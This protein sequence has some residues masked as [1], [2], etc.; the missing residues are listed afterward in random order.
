MDTSALTPSRTAPAPGT[1][2]TPISIA[3]FDVYGTLPGTAVGTLASP[4]P[5]G[6]RAYCSRTA[7]VAFRLSLPAFDENIIAL[8][9]HQ[10]TS[11][12]MLLDR[13]YH[14]TTQP[15]DAVIIP[16][17]FPVQFDTEV[18]GLSETIL[19]C[20]P[21][22]LISKAAE[23]DLEGQPQHVELR[24][25][26]AEQRDPLLHGIGWALHQQIQLGEHCDGL[27]L[28]SLASTLAVHMLRTYAAARPRPLRAGKVLPPLVVRRLYEYIEVHLASALSQEELSVVA[29]YSP[30]H[31]A[32]LFR[33][34][35][36]LSLHE[37]VTQR[38][39][40]R[41]RLLLETTELTLQQIAE[42]TGFSDQSHLSHRF[43]QV[44]GYPPGAGRG[45][46]RSQ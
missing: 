26:A 16:R 35:T 33:R 38:R 39:L 44:Y 45:I 32:R 20:L 40:H 12:K 19:I 43:R 18:K 14:L 42:Q 46:D 7:H 25:F 28:E 17:T 34:T 4:R 1:P 10:S 8:Q 9:L 41:A 36:G 22:Q 27:Y 15:G 13:T 6:V 11:M 2:A 21:P 31:L 24:P 23:W 3:T 5:N 37:Y 29:Q 30:Y